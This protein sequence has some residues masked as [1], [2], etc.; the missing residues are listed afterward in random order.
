MRHCMDNPQECPHKF[1]FLRSAKW[2]DDSGSYNTGYFRVDTFFCER[3]LKYKEIKQSDYA[4]DTP[5]WY[6]D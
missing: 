2:K 3:C 5:T 6:K 4:R 1:V